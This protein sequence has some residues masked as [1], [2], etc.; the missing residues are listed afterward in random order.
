MVPES[1]DQIL[2]EVGLK[3]YANRDIAKLSGGEAQ[4]ISV[5]RTLGNSPLVLLLDEPTSA[6]DEVSKLEIEGLIQKIV[7]EQKLTCVIV[8]HDKA[9]ANRL[10][11]RAVVLESGHISRI[12]P[13]TGGL[14][15]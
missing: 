3:G 15:A 10:A 12:G 1:V 7:R 8:T 11:Q 6:L 14:H 13:T 9:Q 2:T 4:R 5:A